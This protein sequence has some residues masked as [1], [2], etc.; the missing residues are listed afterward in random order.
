M[1][2]ISAGQLAPDFN[3][4]SSE[5]KVVSPLDFRGGWTV[6][7]FYP[8]DDTSGCTKEACGFRD[9]TAEY[10]KRKITVYGVSADSIESH[11]KFIEKY[12]LSFPLLS[13]PSHDMLDDYGV[14]Q[15]KSFLGK[16]SMGVA[17]TTVV[18]DPDGRIA[19]VFTDVKPDEHAQEVLTYLDM[20]MKNWAM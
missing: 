9:L 20:V 17:R 3:L 10:A 11:A 13:D 19:K 4:Q 16:T 7:Y 5:G 2:V 18:I 12:G 6:L 1:G 14:W 8:K 15:E